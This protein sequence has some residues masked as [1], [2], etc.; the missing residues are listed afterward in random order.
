MVV[1]KGLETVLISEGIFLMGSSSDI[2]FDAHYSEQPQ[3]SVHLSTYRIQ[4]VPVTVGLWMQFIHATNY[5]WNRLDDVNKVSPSTQHPITFVSWFDAS[6]FVKWLS[7]TSNQLYALPTEAQWE[8]A[9][10]GQ[11]GQISPWGNEELLSWVDELTL[12][13]EINLPVGSRSEWQSP[14][15]C[16]DMWQNVGEWCLDWFSDNEYC[17][18]P[19]SVRQNPSGPLEGRYKVFRGGNPLTSGWPRCAYRGYWEPDLQHPTLG[20]R[21]V[22]N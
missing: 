4:K 19:N 11:L 15:G 17:G 9:C 6:E 3:R 1:M 21:V 20:F 18:E 10:R 16:L 5:K 14:C 8:R 2:D 22:M 13:S 7:D 12:Y